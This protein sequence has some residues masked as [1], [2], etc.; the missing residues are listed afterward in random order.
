MIIIYSYCFLLFFEAFFNLVYQEPKIMQIYNYVAR[1]TGEKQILFAF[2]SKKYMFTSIIY[3]LTILVEYTILIM[4]WIYLGIFNIVT[5]LYIITLIAGLIKSY[6]IIQRF[7]KH[8]GLIVQLTCIEK[9]YQFNKDVLC[10]NIHIYYFG[11][12]LLL[13]LLTIG[14]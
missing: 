1:K 6:F 11:F 14:G 5:Y 8:D 10:N 12:I 13:I 3:T 2:L 4:S 9:G 7:E